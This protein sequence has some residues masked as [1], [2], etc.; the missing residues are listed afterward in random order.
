[1][2]MRMVE[3]EGSSAGVPREKF[4]RS[5]ANWKGSLAP[6]PTDFLP[7]TETKVSAARLGV[8]GPQTRVWRSMTPGTAYCV[9]VEDSYEMMRKLGAG[10]FGETFLVVH[11]ATGEQLACK[12]VKKTNLV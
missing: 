12:T 9:K 8:A 10:S 11:R 7:I 2:L 4:I 3:E 6:N 1:M 5:Y